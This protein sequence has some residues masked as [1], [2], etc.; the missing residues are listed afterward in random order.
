MTLGARYLFGSGLSDLSSLPQKPVR[1]NTFLLPN[2]PTASLVTVVVSVDTA[3]G[4]GYNGWH[5]EVAE[6]GRRA[7][8]RG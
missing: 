1:V 6:F 8:L 5:A 4:I 2:G 3:W 7:S